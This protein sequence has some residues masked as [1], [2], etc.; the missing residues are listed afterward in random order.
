[1]AASDTQTTLYFT[2]SIFRQSLIFLVIQSYCVHSNQV[3]LKHYTVVWCQISC[4][5]YNDCVNCQ[6]IFQ[7]HTRWQCDIY[8]A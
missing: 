5:G 7:K 2:V 1:M 4:F 6:S 8:L 3:Y